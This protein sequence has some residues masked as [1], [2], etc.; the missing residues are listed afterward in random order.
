MKKMAAK[1]SLEGTGYATLA[2]LYGAIY[3]HI[4]GKDERSPECL[5]SA[6]LFFEEGD[7]WMKKQDVE[8]K[9]QQSAYLHTIVA[10]LCEKHGRQELP[11][12]TSK[13]VR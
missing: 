11:Q 8:W 3:T 9:A 13:I 4:T 6:A 12:E 1:Q 10:D 2:D 5:R 7:A